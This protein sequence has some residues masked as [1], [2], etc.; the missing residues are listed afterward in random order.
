M[1]C[2]PS[3]HPSISQLCLVSTLQAAIFIRSI[4]NSDMI[5]IMTFSPSVLIVK[6][7]WQ[8]FPDQIQTFQTYCII[9]TA[10]KVIFGLNLNC[11]FHICFI[12][13]SFILVH[14]RYYIGFIS[15]TILHILIVLDQLI[16]FYMQEWNHAIVHSCKCQATLFA[17]LKIGLRLWHWSYLSMNRMYLLSHEPIGFRAC[18]HI[19]NWP[20]VKHVINLIST[21]EI[22]ILHT[23]IWNFKMIFIITIPQSVLDWCWSMLPYQRVTSGQAI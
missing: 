23:S 19:S 20:V 22:T 21:L 18:H 4:S 9:M 2:D 15:N 13:V 3:I 17:T 7:V 12:S 1:S 8:F 10:A 14:S 6:Q 11:K 5:F 16:G